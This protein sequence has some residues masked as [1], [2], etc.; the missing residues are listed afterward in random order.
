[1]IINEVMAEKTMG[2][3]SLDFGEFLDVMS[4]LEEKM[5]EDQPKQT[6]RSEGTP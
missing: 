5:K 6:K 4:S 3:D 1:M 2:C